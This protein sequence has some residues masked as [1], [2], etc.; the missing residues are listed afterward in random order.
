MPWKETGYTLDDWNSDMRAT[1]EAATTAAET[2]L[3]KDLTAAQNEAAALKV[4]NETLA[5]ANANLTGENATLK[6]TAEK[7]EKNGVAYRELMKA[8]VKANRIDK[9]LLHLGD[10]AD[11]TTPEK[12]AATIAKMKDPDNGIPEFFTE[13]AAGK[14]G[15][16][17]KG[18]EGDKQTGGDKQAAGGAWGGS[19]GSQS[20]GGNIDIQTRIAEATK[21]GDHL[22]AIALQREA[23]YAAKNPAG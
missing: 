14:E 13:G 16:Q 18:S 8:G 20:G 3:N 4:T 23:A 2:K 12:T 11:F 17:G 15:Q 19:G 7:A 1:R 6:A 9:A 5:A 21:N 10:D 22:G